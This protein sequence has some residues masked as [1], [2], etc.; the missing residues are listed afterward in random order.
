MPK[1][2]LTLCDMAVTFILLNTEPIINT[3]WSC[4]NQLSIHKAEHMEKLLWGSW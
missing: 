4:F 3:F 2:I 1:L